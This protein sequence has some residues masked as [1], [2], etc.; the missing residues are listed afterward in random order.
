[1][2]KIEG[3]EE[4]RKE[5]LGRAEPSHVTVDYLLDGADQI[6]VMAPQMK[7]YLQRKS[8]R[9]TV[10]LIP[11]GCDDYGITPDEVDT[12]GSTIKVASFGIALPHKGLIETAMAVRDLN[13]MG[14]PATLELFAAVNDGDVISSKYAERLEYLIDKYQMNF[15]TW[16][17]DF[18]PKKDIVEGMHEADIIVL[19]YHE[20]R[21][22]LGISG[23]IRTSMGS[24]RPIIMTDNPYFSDLRNL[25]IT[26]SDEHISFSKKFAQIIYETF[27]D[28]ELRNKIQQDIRQ[29]VTK[30]SWDNI[31]KQYVR[32]WK[33]LVGR[34]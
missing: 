6:I 9:A 29:Y 14:H 32:A 17:Q 13:L 34:K 19:P 2:G 31:A 4:C 26:I 25:L 1:M 12:I 20:I 27:I 10:V 18:L 7:N 21:Y 5:L 8:N 11:H 28:L 16:H 23:A 33:K 15:I 22:Q 30:H 24:M 3:F